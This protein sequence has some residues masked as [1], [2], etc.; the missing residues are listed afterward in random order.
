LNIQNLV[1]MANSIGDFFAAWPDRQQACDEIASHL[2][3]FWDP[4]MRAEI[5]AH[6]ENTG[7]EG[8][9]AIVVEAVRRLEAPRAT[10]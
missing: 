4:R 2:K 3:R 9:D 6:V 5:I 1:K 7:G 8:L 10:A